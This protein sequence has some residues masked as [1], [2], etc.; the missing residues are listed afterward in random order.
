MR[1]F[2]AVSA[3]VLAA[4][5]AL[6]QT[7]VPGGTIS[8]D[9]TWTIGGS[10]YTVTGT[11]SVA[12]T[13][14]A[15]GITTLT[16][17]PGVVV[18]FDAGVQ[19]QIGGTAAG[20]PGALVADGNATG[21]PALIRFTSSSATPA[22]G[23][24]NGIYFRSGAR[25]SIVRNARIEYGGGSIWAGIYVS[26]AATTVL[27]LDQLQIANNANQGLRAAGP[28]TLALTD[29]TFAANALDDVALSSNAGITGSVSGCT[30]H[31]V[32]YAG[33]QPAV[34]W[35]G[36]TFQDWGAR[37]SNIP[38]NDI[39]DFAADNTFLKVANAQVNVLTDTIAFDATWTVAMADEYVT[40]GSQAVQGTDGGDGITTLTL[41]PGVVVRFG[42]GDQLQIGGTAA[43]TPGALVADGDATG[44]PAQILF[45]S[46]SGTPAPGSWA[47]IYFRP[48]ARA[49]IVRNARIEY[50]GASIWAGI[51]VT[52][53]AATVLTLDQLQIEDSANEGLHVTGPV[54][55]ALTDSTFAANALDDVAL[56]SNA[57]ITGSVSGCTLRSVNYAG[58][59]P[60]VTWSGNT[61]QEWGARVSNIPG[62]DI[63]D[64]AADNTFLKV[65]AAQVNV[66]QDTIA[67]DA[68]WTVA[69]ADA[70]VTTGSQAIQGTDGGDGI[71]TLTLEPGL[72]LRFGAGDQLQVGGTSA[73]VA[74]A[75]VADGDA[76]GGPARIR[77]TSSSGA[78]TRGSW[79]GIYFRSGARTSIVRNARV[80]YA[81]ASV[82]A[83]IYAGQ[84]TGDTVTIDDVLV[85]ESANYGVYQG[86]PTTMTALTVSGTNANAV[87]LASGTVSI[88]GCD[89]DSGSDYDVYVS[90]VPSVTGSVQNCPVIHSVF[91]AGSQPA[92]SWSGNTFVDWGA[93]VSRLEPEAVE[94]I[95]ADNTVNLTPGA[96][97]E[98][99][100]GTVETDA[101]WT[102]GL[103]KPYV[104]LGS[105]AVQGTSGADGITTLTIAPGLE[106]RFENGNQLQIGGTAAAVPGALVA[107]GDAPGGPAQIRFTS[108]SPS[109]APGSWAGIYFRA[110]A[111]S[112]VLRN[113]RIDY[114]GA[115]VWAPVYV[116]SA[117]ATVLT[118]DRLQIE[119]NDS[120]GLEVVG[121]AT[122]ALTDSTFAANALDDV[123][124][125]SNAGI[126]GSVSGCTLHSVNYAGNQ[127]AISWSGNTFQDWGARVSRIPGNDVGDFAADNTFVKV[128]AAT[129]D[130]LADTIALDAT[131]T[132]A[133]ADAYVALGSQT[134]QGTDGGDGVTTLTLEPGAELRFG[135]GNQLQ[136]GGVS[137]GVPGALVADGDAT[138]GPARIL[139]TSSSGTP[140]PGDWSGI[141]VRAGARASILRNARVEY[142]GASVWADVYASNAAETLTV[143]GV[144]VVDSG[145]YGVYAGGAGL[146]IANSTIEGNADHDVY[147]ANSAT[148]TGSVQDSTLESAFYA[149]ALADVSWTG[150]TFNTWGARTS[151][152]A[153]RVVGQFSTQNTFNALPGAVL[154]VIGGTLADDAT[155]SPAP[156]PFVLTTSLT[157]QGTSG[158]DARTTLTLEPGVALRFP[159]STGLFVGGFSG[160]P[161]ELVASG[162]LGGGAVSNINF[163]SSQAIPAAGSWRGVEVRATGRATIQDAQ[164]SYADTG[165][166]VNGGT[167]DLLQSLVVNRS[168]VGVDL[169]NSSPA[170]PL[171][172]MT[173]RN[174]GIAV[175]ASNAAATIQNGN[176]EGSSFGVQNLSPAAFCIDAQNNWWGDPSGPSGP[177]PAVGCET[178]QAT[179]TGSPVT[180]GVRFDAF[181]GT[182][183][184]DLDA[185]ACDDGDGIN[186]PCSGGNTVDCDDNCCLVANPS[187]ADADGD[188]VGDACDGNPVLRVSSDPLDLPDFGVVQDAVDAAFQSGTRIEIFPGLGP[189]VES[190]RLDREQVFTL[191][192]LDEPSGDPVIV[193]GLTGPA[194]DAV[195]KVG[196][197]PMSL[198]HVTLRGNRGVHAL[199]D[200]SIRDVVFDGVA[201]EALA[202]DAGSHTLVDA[203]IGP[204]QAVGVDVGAGAAISMERVS[205]FGSTDAGIVA[206]GAVTAVSTLV[207]GGNGADGIRASG[208]GSLTLRFSTVADNTGYG[209]DNA[210]IGSLVIDRSIVWGNALDDL[211]VPA[212]ASATWS[213]IGVPDCSAAGNNVA[214][215][216]LLDPAYRLSSGSVCLEHG[217]DPATFTGTPVW[218]LDSTP[219]LKDYDADGFAN[220]DCGAFEASDPTIVPGEVLNLRWTSSFRLEWDAEPDALEYHVYRDLASNLSWSSFAV[221][222]DGLDGDRTDTML[223]DLEDPLP[224]QTFVY[225]ITAEAADGHEGTLGYAKAAERSNYP[226]NRCP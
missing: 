59:Q 105:I 199:V 144:E 137:A 214:G 73:G 210:S 50:G 221:C 38:G 53:A 77:F 226:A 141:Y 207:A 173:I 43:G 222:A 161:G 69:M 65:P 16:I 188:G 14:G 180:E 47:G 68:T 62:N 58:N 122:I 218:D 72:E 5:A 39:D 200:T 87:R 1:S 179:G 67:L 49:S 215:D 136:I 104:A 79:A 4:S 37:V 186:D 108:S 140:A 27:T 26:S 209:I 162:Q 11:V 165:M 124:L 45:T 24:W 30:L 46:A 84:S 82:W 181:L 169:V 8:T 66:L 150:N 164:V 28:V 135:G 126:T 220:S 90:A 25:A 216:P 23:D 44:G 182:P 61:F 171:S 121:P 41:E 147:V 223:D 60:A 34:T 118:L 93:R 152:V 97:L 202:L 123:A 29:S 159:A 208:T 149:G 217:P 80:D 115:S 119:N 17:A 193:D 3:A 52:S 204:A 176:L 111:R 131:W 178:Q 151:R 101:S 142:G 15:D 31:S 64:F 145:N 133:M 32:S 88:S 154:E 107:D 63:D 40:T 156:G 96:S 57:G 175:R 146:S 163:G 201:G 109:P 195:N 100:G 134:V 197:A 55:L 81:G 48:G 205:I 110:G 102:A 183:S 120:D 18:L 98:L 129:V 185:I 22:P 172:E 184:D 12:G 89:L 157:V 78:P 196:V 70:Y 130:V 33:N 125:A 194:F 211:A 9:T 92:V 143:D 51:Y 19:L 224:G 192:G 191:V 116:S 127:P 103:G 138:G 7:T 160:D 95:R 75:L 155:W 36:N 189:Y 35:S 166:F 212:C 203:G 139:F 83:G 74:G 114:A 106:L 10:P 112:S 113:A 128:P 190:V 213:D 99:T 2:V 20:T 117:A 167:I 71:T 198:S 225:L 85:T 86:G 76:T 219:R 177:V 13:D 158:A 94:D 56:S 206:G 132:V 148:A 187:Q 153:P 168:N 174:T 6:A 21:G 54:T 42:A 91:Y 170:T